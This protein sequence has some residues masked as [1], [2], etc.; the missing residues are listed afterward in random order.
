MAEKRLHL[1]LLL[2]ALGKER[3]SCALKGDLVLEIEIETGLVVQLRVA[4]VVGGG[5]WLG[6]W[7]LL[8][9]SDAPF[10]LLG[11][12][13]L[14]FRLFVELRLLRLRDRLPSGIWMP[15]CEGLVGDVVVCCG[16]VR[17]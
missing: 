15:F 9:R 12:S 14:L 13:S 5:V 16:V 2:Q 7:L 4:F 10:R 3:F 1:P 11:V 17:G 6:L 8:L